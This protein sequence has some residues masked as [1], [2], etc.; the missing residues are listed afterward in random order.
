M[1]TNL[2]KLSLFLLSFAAPLAMASTNDWPADCIRLPLAPALNGPGAQAGKKVFWV[3]SYSADYEHDV[4]KRSGIMEALKGSGVELTAFYMDTKSDD[5]TRY[6]ER[7]GE[8]A[9]ELV[10]WLKPDVVIA[11]DDNAQKYLVVPHLKNTALPVVFMAVNWDASIYGFPAS[12]VTGMVE[13]E[14][15]RELV[16]RMRRFAR[17]DR[18]GYIGGNVETERKIVDIYNQRFF[19]GKMTNYLV[20]SMEEFEREYRR[21]QT[22]VDM[23]MV[24]SYTGIRDW[25]A[26]RARKFI[27]AN[28]RIPSGTPN[29]FMEQFVAFVVAKSMEEHGVYAGQTALTILGGKP[30]GSIPLCENT[31]MLLSLNVHVAKS[32]GIIFPV[33]ML[34]AARVIGQS[35]LYG[36]EKRNEP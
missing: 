21:A 5:S 7:M 12:N 4:D 9:Y 17:G 35:G 15:V 6:G 36:D 34:K 31:R 1:K 29:R 16:A 32:A 13:V 26:D 24:S 23:L 3:S 14:L 22:E 33:S 2:A 28:G 30:P 20:T 18:V 25:D 10:Q 8:R 19:A 11:S 27:L